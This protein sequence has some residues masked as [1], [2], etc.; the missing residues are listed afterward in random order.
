[1]RRWTRRATSAQNC[2]LNTERV[3]SNSNSRGALVRSVLSADSVNNVGLRRN[4]DTCP[5]QGNVIIFSRCV[6]SSWLQSR[7][8]K[9]RNSG[10]WAM[11]ASTSTERRCTVRLVRWGHN[12]LGHVVSFVVVLYLTA[13][14]SSCSR[15]V[16]LFSQSKMRGTVEWLHLTRVKQRS[17]RWRSTCTESVSVT[18]VSSNDCRVVSQ[19]D[20]RLRVALL[21]EWV[22][23]SELIAL[24]HGRASSWPDQSAHPS[25]RNDVQHSNTCLLVNIR[26]YLRVKTCFVHQSVAW[27]VD[28]KFSQLGADDRIWRV[29]SIAKPYTQ[30]SQISAGLQNRLESMFRTC[31]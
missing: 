3:H 8:T 9:W 4:R 26:K 19:W 15:A 25:T 2:S 23:C 7:S 14:S 6:S 24:R 10:V 17:K 28:V 13:I 30:R 27:F 16:H 18:W 1:M 21:P 31:N 12:S 11:R 22:R 20:S 29:A 5:I